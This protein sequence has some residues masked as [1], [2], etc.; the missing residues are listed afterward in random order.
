MPIRIQRKRTKGWKMPENTF[1]VGRPGKFGNPLKLVG[2]MIY[3]DASWRRSILGKWVYFQQGTIDDVVNY[4]ELLLTGEWLGDNED[5]K[6]WNIKLHELN[7][8]SLKGKDLSCFCSLGKPC[9]ADVLLK[10][11]N[12]LETNT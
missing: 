5:M 1:Y 6:Y 11:A 2:D 7:L 8:Q 3:I 9:H 4:Y 12:G 10:I